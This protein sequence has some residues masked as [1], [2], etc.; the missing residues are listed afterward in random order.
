MQYVSFNTDSFLD[1][2]TKF[3]TFQEFDYY[4]VRKDGFWGVQSMDIPFM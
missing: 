4:V 1:D 3:S 2:S